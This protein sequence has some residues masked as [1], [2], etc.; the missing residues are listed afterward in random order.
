MTILLYRW[1]EIPD[2]LKKSGIWGNSTLARLHRNSEQ[3]ERSVRLFVAAHRYWR[4]RASGEGSG[5]L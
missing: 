1:V 5:D 2:F 3:K 4:D